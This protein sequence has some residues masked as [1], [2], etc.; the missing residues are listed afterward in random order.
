MRHSMAVPAARTSPQA[1]LAQFL[2]AIVG[3]SVLFGFTLIML[4]IGFNLAYQGKIFPGIS[5]AGID[6]SGMT[7]DQAILTIQKQIA[8]ADNGEI[9]LQDGKQIW[10]FHP[11]ELGFQI[12]AQRSAIAAY[13]LG[14]QGGIINRFRAIGRAIR[15]DG[16]ISPLMIYDERIAQAV[17]VNIAQQINTPLMEATLKINGKQVEAVPGKVGRTLDIQA[18]LQSIQ[19]QILTLTDGI[20][21]LVVQEQS[22]DILDASQQAEIARSI[23]SSPLILQIPERSDSDPPDWQIQPEELARMVVIQRVNEADKVTYQVG[24]RTASLESLLQKIAKQIDRQPQNARFIFNDDTRQLELIQPALVGRTLDV[25][26]TLQT[27]Q[28]QLLQGKHTIPLVIKTAQPAIGNDASAEKLGIRELVSKYT[29]YFYGSSA[30]RIQNI[31][32]AAA[33]FHGVL[34]APGETFSMASVLGDVSL[35]NGYAEALIIYGDRTIKGV[36]GGVCQVST[37]LF[38]TAFFGGYP[39]VERHPHAY[40]VTYYEQ[41]RTGAIDPQLAGLDAT[42]FVPVVDFKFTND[43]PYWLLMET[44]INIAARTLTWKFYSTSDGRT[45][46]WQTSGLQN[47]VEPGDPIVQENPDLAENEFRQVDWAAEGADVTITRT[48]YKNGTIYFEDQF[49]THYM[50]W[51]AVYEYGPGSN[52]KKFNQWLQQQQ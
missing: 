36:G 30:A 39:I 33:R 47:I 6:L 9:V 18:S 40:R 45:V 26:T 2:I 27:I 42:V 41:T 34:V 48:V 17:L 16:Y 50:P 10:R 51:Q 21:P 22:P 25:T 31:Q 7:L 37:T 24:L 14:R 12:D 20:V 35:D 43:T 3:G 23:L 29:S 44:Y 5:M 4:L 28:E 38:R 46:E 19:S 32:T 1:L 11:S 13:N 8:Y 15:K 49:I 52:M